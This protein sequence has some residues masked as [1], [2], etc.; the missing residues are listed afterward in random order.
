MKVS[1]YGGM[2]TLM[3]GRSSTKSIGYLTPRAWIG[4]CHGSHA[5]GIGL[6]SSVPMAPKIKHVEENG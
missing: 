4:E 5:V 1:R 3:Y 2:T 6:E